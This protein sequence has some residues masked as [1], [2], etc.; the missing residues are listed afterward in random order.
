MA[1][2]PTLGFPIVTFRILAKMKW[3]ACVCMERM[4]LRKLVCLKSC[5][6]LSLMF[7]WYD[8][9]LNMCLNSWT[10]F[11]GSC[12]QHKPQ[13]CVLAS[14][15]ICVTFVVCRADV[16]RI[17]CPPL[18]FFFFFFQSF[19]YAFFKVKHII[20]LILTMVGVIGMKQ[21]WNALVGYWVNYVT[22]D[23][24]FGFFKVKF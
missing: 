6:Y 22:F 24:V 16:Y 11:W 13:M 21:K 7:V 3:S 23:L 15:C 1:V 18:S 19:G 17:I 5:L 20:G 8:M 10:A 4:A 12:V 2:L 14:A 9:S